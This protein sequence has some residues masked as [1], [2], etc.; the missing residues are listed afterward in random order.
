MYTP[1]SVGQRGLWYAQQLNPHLPFTVA[2]YVELRGPLDTGLVAAACD[3]AAREVESGVLFIESV[4]GE[5]HQRLEPDVD[6]A[7]G[8][9]DLGG[10][11]DPAVAAMRFMVEVYSRPLDPLR[12]RLIGTTLIRLGDDHHYLFTHVHHLALD[13]HGGMVLLTRAAELYTAW[14]TG[15][16]PPPLRAMTLARITEHELAYQGSARQATDRQHWAQ[17]LDRLPAPVT[18]SDGAA[19]AAP[20]C[21][22]VSATLGV[23]T[24]ADVAEL[25]RVHNS[26]DVPVVIAAFVSY[27]GRLTGAT[28]IGLSL[29]VSARTTAALRRSAGSMSNVVPLRVRVESGVRVADLVRRVQVELTGALRHQRYRYEDMLRDLHAV[30]DQRETRSAFGPAVNMMMFQPEIVFGCVTGE[31]HVLSTGPVDDLSLNVYP[32]VAGRS[33]RVDFEANPVRY[34]DTELSRH[35]RYFLDHLAAFARS[36]HLPVEAVPLGVP[37]ETA[38]VAPARGPRSSGTAMLPDLLT[39]H[40]DSDRVAVRDGDRTLTYRELDAR[41]SALAREIAGA[42]AGPD[43][44]VAVLLPRS[45]ALVVAVWA[46]AKAGAAYTPVDPAS[47]EQRLA[48][49]L[50]HAKVAI[51]DDDIRLPDGVTRLRA[52]DGEVPDEP[53]APGERVR[54]LR[55]DHVAWVIHT[56]GSSG[57]PKAVAVTHRGLAGLVDSLRTHYRADE[58]SRVLLLAAPS[59]DASMEELLLAANAGATLVVGPADAVAGADLAALLREQRVTH[60]AATPSVLAVTDPVDLPALRLVDAG[61]EALPPDVAG[62]W[63]TGRTLL[64]TY[65]PTEATVFA[66]L[67]GPLRADGGVPIGHPVHGMAAV[68]LDAR[69]RPLP[70]GAVG[71]LYLV[72]PALARGYVGDPAQTAT[73]FVASPYGR[74]YRTGDLVRWRENGLVFVGRSDRQVQIRG[75]R[76]EPAEVEV[77]LTGLRAVTAAAVVARGDRLDAYV[78][79][80]AAAEDIRRSLADLLPA[81]LVPSTLTVLGALPLTVSGKLDRPA[82]PAPV[83]VAGTGSRP[84]TGATETLVGRL[85]A[86]LVADEPG[87]SEPA[88]PATLGADTSFFTVGGHSLGAARLAGR[89]AAATG[90]EVHLRDVFDHPTIAELAAFVDTAPVLAPSR[91]ASDAGGLAPLAPAQQRLWLISQSGGAAYHLSVAL[92]FDG[93]LDLRALRAALGDVIDRHEPLRTVIS[94]PGPH[95]EVRPTAQVLPALLPEPTDADVD[96]LATRVAGW[97]ALPFDL[98]TDIPLRVRLLNLGRGRYVLVAVAHHIAVDGASVAVLVGDLAEAY[99][100]RLAGQAPAWSPLPLRFVDHAAGQHATLG[101]PADPSSRAA[102]EIAYWTRRL[103]GLG[104]AEGVPADHPRGPVPGPAVAIDLHVPAETLAPL[105]R[106]AAEHEATPFMLVH[107]AVAVWMSRWTGGRDVAVGTGT[108]GRDRPELDRLVGMFVGT[109]TLR[110]DVDPGASFSELLASSR[111]A[112]LDAHTHAAVPFDQVV[113]A[114]GYSPFQVMLAFDDVGTPDVVLPAVTVGV[115]EMNSPTARFDVELSVGQSADGTLIGRLIYDSSRFEHDTVT[116]AVADLHDVVTALASAPHSPVGE[117]A[118]GDRPVAVEPSGPAVTLPDLLVASGLRMAEPG[119]EALDAVQAATPLA[120]RLIDRGLGPEDRVAVVLP[121]SLDSVRAV[122]AVTLAGSA[123]VAV[124]PAQPESRIR[125]LLRGSQVRAAIAPP[126]TALPEGVERIDPTTEDSGRGPVTAAD[127][128]RPLVPDHAAYLVHTSGSTGIPKAVV[129]THRGLGPLAGDLRTRMSLDGSARVLHCASPTFDASMLEYLMAAAGGGTLVVAP[130]DVYGGDELLDLVREERIT[131]WFSTPAI[132]AQLDPSGLDTLR[133]LAVGGEAWS[134]E[135]ATR[136]APG[137]TMLN[138]YGPTETTVLAT[139][140]SPLRPGEPLTLGDGLDGVTALVLGPRLAPAP[141]GSIG[142]LYLMGPGLARGYLDDPAR[143][144]GRFVASPFGAGRMYRTGDLVRRVLRGERVQLVFAGRADEQVKVR[145]FRIEPG[146]VDATLAVHPGVAAAVTVMHGDG[147][148]SYVHGPGPL[149]AAELRAFLAARLPRHLVPATVTVLESLPL[150]RTGKIDR[151]ALPEPEIVSAA[152]GFRS[153]AEE[154]V[155]SIVSEVLSLPSVGATDDF[156]ALGGNSLS[157]TRLAARLG[158]AAGR[159]VAV[160]EVFDHPTVAALAV[161]LADPAAARRLPLLPAG[162]N[163]PAPLAAAQQR[164]WLVN[165]IDVADG[166]P[167]D[168]IAFAVDLDGSTGPDVLAA[169]ASDVLDRHAVLRTI[170]PDGADG[171]RQHVRNTVALDLT[172]RPE[173]ADLDAH[174]AD[175]ASTGFDL[176]VEPPL[177][178]RLYRRGPGHTLAVVLHHIAVDGLSLAPLGRD[179]AVALAARLEGH[180]PAWPPLAVSYRDYTLWQREVL[181][182]PADPQSLAGRQLAYWSRVLADASPVLTLPADRPGADSPGAAGR[183][184][185]TVHA[186]LH[187]AIDKLAREHDATPFMVMHAA[188]ALMLAGVAATEDVIV[189]TPVSGRVDELLDDVVGM[190]VGT[191]ALRLPVRPRATFAQ[192]LD[193]AR[194]VDLDALAHAD[195]PFDLVVDAL[196]RSASTHHPVF[197]VMFSYEGFAALPSE[198]PGISGVRE[199]GTGTARLDLDVTVRETRSQTGAPTGLD[200]VLTYD[201]GRYDHET[202]DEWASMLVRVLDAV[203]ADPTVQIGR[204]DLL[205]PDAAAGTGVEWVTGPPSIVRVAEQVRLRPDS[206]ALTHDDAVLTYRQLWS[207]S[208]ALA[209]MLAGR[210]IGTEDLVAVALPRSVD[211]VVA[212]VA[213]ARTGAAYLPLDVSHPPTRLAALIA[214]ARPALVLECA[215]VAVETDVCRLRVDTPEFGERL[216]VGGSYDRTTH[217]D[218]IGYVIHTSGSTGAPKGVAVPNSALASLF[219][220]TDSMGFGAGDVWPLVHSPAFDVSVWEMWGAL[221]TGGRLVVVD[222]YTVRDPQALTALVDREGVTVLNLTPTAFYQLASVDARLPSLRLLNFAGEAFDPERARAWFTS[223]P[224]VVATNLYGIT[225]TTVHATRGPAAAAGVGTALP[226]LDIAVLDSS[227]RTAPTGTTGELHVSGPQL[228]RGYSGRPGLTA[229]RFVAAPGGKRRYRSGDL[230]RRDRSGV[231]HHH[232]RADQQ[233]ELRGHRVEPGEVEAAL[234]RCPG[235][236]QA[237]VVL[238]GDR[239]V[240]YLVGGEPACALSTLRSAL[241]DHMVPSALVPLE[242]LPRTVNGKLD[243][244]ALPDPAPH[245]GHGTAPHS[246]LEELV[247]EVFRELVGGAVFA[248][249]DDFFAVGGNSLLATRLAGRLA[250]IAD[251]DVT[252]RDVFEAPTVAALAAVLGARSGRERLR[253]PLDVAPEGAATP[254]APAQQ[255][256]WFLSRLDPD[257][258]GYILPFTAVLDGELDVAALGA[259]IADVQRRHRTLRTVH[260]DIE[261]QV[262]LSPHASGVDPVDVQS[263]DIDTVVRDFVSVP[264]DLTTDLP[265]RVRLFRTAPRRHVLAVVIHH[266]A[267]DGWS[268]DVLLRDLASAYTARLSG[269]EPRWTPLPVHYT[270]YARHQQFT[271]DD[272]LEDWLAELADLP[273]EVTLPGDR[274]RPTRPSG[275][276]AT[277]R[278]TLDPPLSEGITRLARDGRATVFMVLH[279]ALAVLLTR[280][281]AGRDIAIGT[282]V[283]GRDDP[284]LDDLVG[285]FA[286]TL[287]LRTPVDADSAFTDLLS[288]VR[289]RDVAAFTRPDAPFETLVERLAPPR[290]SGRHPLFQVAL[291]LRGPAAE[292]VRLPGL[293][294][295]VLPLE[296]EY[297]NFDLQLT[298]TERGADIEVEFAYATDLYD[299]ETVA[300]FADRFDRILRSAVA[301]PSVRVGDMEL[302]TDGRVSGPVPAP[303]RSLWSLLAAGAGR[304][305]D[306]VA[307]SGDED[308]TYAELLTTAETLAACLI[309]RGVRPGDAVA[310]AIPRSH[311]SVVAVWAMVRAGAAPMFVDPEQPGARVESMLAGTVV[312]I[313]TSAYAAT[314]PASVAWIDVSRPGNEPACPACPSAA[315]PAPDEAAYF[316]FTSGTTGNPK[317]VAVTHRGVSA[318]V[319]DLS[320]RFG[321]V[322]GDRMLHV[323]SPTFDAAMLEILVA[324]TTGATL[325]VAPLDT[326]GGAPLGELIAERGVTHACLTPSALASLPA[327]DLPSLRVLMLG[328]E[329]VPPDL[330]D[331]WGSGRRLYN[332][333]GPAEGTVFVT[334]SPALTPGDVPVIGT[335]VR[336]V[337]AE[338]LDERLHPVPVGVAG[339]LYVSGDR[340]AGGYRRDSARTA[341]RFVAAGAGR[342]RY[343]TGDVVRVR[344]DGALEYLGRTDAQVK[345]RGVRIEPGEV[346]TALRAL[347]AVRRA[348]T[349]A[350]RG[351]LVS[352]V[353]PAETSAVDPDRVRERLREVLPTHLVPVAVVVV[354]TMPLTAHGKLDP[355]RLPDPPGADWTAPVSATEELVASTFADVLGTTSQAGRFDDFF[356]VGGNSLLVTE[357]IGRLREATGL[358][359]PLRLVFEHPTVEA[360]AAAVDAGTFERVAGPAAV[361]PRPDRIPLSRAQHRL[362]VS[363]SLDPSA[364]RLQVEV[365]FTGP[366]DEGA[367]DAAVT[368]VIERHEI[369]RSSVEVDE[370]GPHLVVHDRAAVD[371]RASET[372]PLRHGRVL[373]VDHT[374]AD[375]ASLAPLLRDLATA[376]TARSVGSE[377]HWAALPLQYADYALWERDRDIDHGEQERVE[378][379]LDELDPVALPTE[380]TGVEP[381]TRTVNF[382]IPAETRARIAQLGRAHGATEFMVVHAALSVLLSRLGAGTDVTIAAVVSTR[383]W[384][385]LADVVGPF[386]QTLPLRA[387]V[388]PDL[389]FG[390]V[391]DHVRDVDVAA[392][393]NATAPLDPLAV[394]AVPQVALA[395]QDFAPGPVRIGDVEVEAREIVPDSAPKFDLHIALTP[396]PDGYTGALVYDASRFGAATVRRLADRFVAVVRAV[397]SAPQAEV[398]DIAVDTAAPALVGSRPGAPATLPELLRTAA[399][400]HPDREALREGDRTLTYRELDTRTDALAEELRTSGAAPGVVIPIDLPR[401]L[402]HVCMLWAV[403]KTGAAF[404]SARDA[405]REVPE[406]VAYIV[407]TSGSTGTPKLVAVTHRGLGP[408]AAE[409]AVRY[410]VGPGDRVLHGYDPAFDAALLEIL[411]AHTTGATLV[412]APA[413]VYAGEELQA[414]LQRERVTH[415]LSTPA[416]LGTLDPATLPDLRVVASGGETLPAALAARW[417]ARGRRMLDA[418]GPTEATIVATLT[419]VDGRGGIGRPI[420]GTGAEVLDSRLSPVPVDAVGELYLSGTSLAAGYLGEPGMTA[421]RFVAAAGGGRRYRTGDLVHRRTDDTLAYRGRTDRQV[422]VRGVR[423]EPGEIEAALLRDPAVRAAVA[424]LSRDALVAFVAADALDPVAARAGLADVVPP[425]RMPTRV[426]VVP[427]LPTTRNGKVDTAALRALDAAALRA[428][429]IAVPSVADR[430]VTSAERRVLAV[431]ESVIGILPHPDS[432]F[433]AAGG[434]SLSA[435]TVAARLAGEFGVAVPARSILRAPTL[436]AL[437]VELTSGAP[438]PSIP[439]RRFEDELPVPLAPAQERLWVLARGGTDDGAYA[440]PVALHLTGDLDT[441]ALAA[442]VADV[443][444]RHEVL[445][446]AYPNGRATPVDPP[447]LVQLPSSDPGAVVAD[448]LAGRFDLTIEPPLR[449][450]LIAVGDHEWVLAGALHHSAFDGASLDPLLGDLRAA[451]TARSAGTTPR[452]QPLPVR[453]RDFAH[454]QHALLGDPTDA[455]SL[456]AR[457]LDHWADVLAGLPESPLPLPADRIRPN[458]PSGRGGAV[459]AHLDAT[460][461]RR[462]MEFAQK[463]DVSLFM[464]LHAAL[465]VMLARRSGRADVAVGTVVSGR[466]DPRLRMLVGMFVGTLTLRTRIDAAEPFAGLLRRVRTVDLD[467][468]AH[469]DVPFDRVVER[470]APVRGGHHPLFQILLAHRLVDAGGERLPSFPGLTVRE[471]D[472]GEP[473]AQFD[474]AFDVAERGDIGGVDVRVVYAADL[475]DRDTGAAMLAEY[476]AVLVDAVEHPDR[477]VGDLAVVA[478]APVATPAV[479]ARTLPRILADTVRAHPGAIAIRSGTLAWT[480]AGLDARASALAGELY[481]RGVGRGDVVAIALPRGPHWPLAVW[482]I[483]RIGA[484][485]MSIDPAHPP[486]RI[487]SMLQDADVHVGLAEPGV[488]F[489]APG[490]EWLDATADREAREIPL[491]DADL[492]D[493]AYLVHTSGSTGIPKAVAVPHRGL[494]ALVDIQRRVLGHGPGRRILAVSAYTFDAAV[495]DLLAAHAHGATMVIAPPDVYAGR[496]LQDMIVDE[497]ITHLGV[498]PT[499][500]GTLDP[501]AL[502]MP[503]TVVSAGELL[504]APLATRWHRHRLFNGYGP[505]ESTVAVSMGGPNP[506]GTRPVVGA[507]VAGTTGHV[508]DGRLHPVPVG[509]IGEL[510]VTGAGLARGYHQQSGLTATRFV[511]DPYGAHGGR[512]YRTGDLARITQSGELDVVGRMDNQIQ[513]RGIRVEPSE[514]DAVLVG[515]HGVDAAVTVAVTGPAGD[516]TLVSYAGGTAGVAELRALAAARLP[517]GVR[518]TAIAVLPTLPLLPS[519]KVDRSALPAPVFGRHEDEYVAP[520]GST[521]ETIA[522]I[523]AG[524]LAVDAVSADLNYFDLGGTSLGALDVV[525]DLRTEF[526][527]DLPL[528]WL[529]TSPTLQAFADRVDGRSDDGGVGGHDGDPLGTLVP[530]GGRPDAAPLFCVHPISG[531][532]WC[533]AGLATHLPDAAVHGVQATALQPL[534]GTLTGF[535]RRYVERLRSV[536]PEGPYRLLGWSVGGVVAHEMAVQ[537]QEAGH[538]VSVLILLDSYSADM[539]PERAPHTAVPYVELDVP[540]LTDSVVD[541]IRSRAMAAGEAIESAAVAHRPRRFSGDA[542]VIRAGVDDHGTRPDWDRYIDGAVAEH[543]VPHAHADLTTPA[544]LTAVGPIV[545]EYLAAR[546]CST[547]GR[548]PNSVTATRETA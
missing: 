488:E 327:R 382:E 323:A 301:D 105:R 178:T 342:R 476:I 332:G 168:L 508:L 431:A 495:F 499:V 415:Y 338:I 166:V 56:S 85:F 334:C 187:S 193:A 28:D 159:R 83:V 230:G 436:A 196:G 243:R 401:G 216:R 77:A 520:R 17:R 525:A 519:G 446:T 7:P 30:G 462:A 397:V 212:I 29:P 489:E 264:F 221:T 130:A 225:E 140:G 363:G 237:A 460:L 24:A 145:G 18:L 440:V 319:D 240:G 534:P 139:A 506:T 50:R 250:A 73:R 235:V 524:H 249:S 33:L 189:G 20:T 272:V 58:D 91:V 387:H 379:S 509:V 461:H 413:A 267:A 466:D 107:T 179:L 455:G 291:S 270:D 419:D 146:E 98:T 514:V 79:A 201:A 343:R 88:G 303:A 468:I 485:W 453:Y 470:L 241:P 206:V 261:T 207:R 214:D 385:V 151:T 19:P 229:T 482:A 359:V 463:H 439:L 195:V 70:I 71:E 417:T 477:E 197:Q 298:V 474:L 263:S 170:H 292:T 175:F 215:E 194:H 537:L 109:V 348:A 121:R 180:A 284:R 541:D 128:V 487:A 364:Y 265:L 538:E 123:F 367:L 268:L 103:N 21:R 308:V 464:V 90:R 329:S 257:A 528:E 416:V 516:R 340:V 283:A 6:D 297:S 126:G 89:L 157:A 459:T 72:G 96:D 127:R 535:A 154:L 12:D 486:S 271:A 256:L 226:G 457:Q 57:T 81:Y 134:A 27:L 102:H 407:A 247:A 444:D 434:D 442:A 276:G 448:L 548:A 517:R 479:A 9:L 386:L 507:P 223:H 253:R 337:T 213:V 324:G 117:L 403:T 242:A 86:E 369:L 60:L 391:L 69:L 467:A 469:A 39:R 339:E 87:R 322:P 492:D 158:A 205:G 289:R 361:H 318:L 411:L 522:A 163:E 523:I 199:L 352:Y 16:E 536:Q 515:H 454:W 400:A 162:G 100:A 278:L 290:R 513:L 304:G 370:H 75:Q 542:L 192:L 4:G 188:L 423:V 280:H 394:G 45:V 111:A 136:W 458:R 239:L 156:F 412:V 305:G 152:T 52:S 174:L 483:T 219:T 424:M 119:G 137:R 8:Y 78:V 475:F 496:P 202:V 15:L 93:D 164:L 258:T 309:A 347:P 94:E 383:R 491:T 351:A 84:L 354:D 14:A 333:Y 233:I 116:A 40:A 68:V 34:D 35:H 293:E 504:P 113:E 532:S 124:D 46:V 375:G 186:E 160:R 296:S 328:G 410:R 373:T 48:T 321:T 173:P 450:R 112:V 149:V 144:A 61:G 420:P 425:H 527:N 133:V 521:A 408:L 429:D 66:T 398:G 203:T 544:A 531:M 262:V 349:V 269:D 345:L 473:A 422:K 472:A 441:Q 409:G 13:G 232:G 480:Y 357:L 430:P 22:H 371:V 330:V 341:S 10:S 74:A 135:T 54:P 251:V 300:A 546:G 512:L 418:Y 317:A 95:Q 389:S 366:V 518:P 438:A 161:A 396:T 106:L 481:A 67:G 381:G 59:F 92:H 362:W 11:P 388:S 155:A 182:D 248:A 287:V 376:Y 65:G 392:F 227:L 428:S 147:L 153:A 503:V 41:S 190:F 238:R 380:D 404:T 138:V 259:A 493:V 478:P 355:G 306:G 5:P 49:L 104:E 47:S 286:G 44:C 505:S 452:W 390:R 31:L 43:D 433:Y 181:G 471:Y 131:H 141:V 266:I 494:T 277:H 435:V 427:Q 101:D 32:A 511:A 76:V 350:R 432:S 36:A 456:A 288:E 274:P 184:T 200:G 540:G 335:P 99:T 254:L 150:T 377:P 484:A 234:L 497:G 244:A 176:T 26:T 346:D 275:H 224:H 294:V 204:I 281:G 314:L 498:T 414:L 245:H 3:R 198:I 38:T 148:A 490:V 543:S 393:D 510:Y 449:I 2:Q 533:Y 97:T 53:F 210:G 42:G 143:T 51:C 372:T 320:E 255:R 110:V 295:Q 129:V 218:A 358:A 132:P 279:T 378:R 302:A 80:S 220:A 421:A 374:A 122:V 312:G 191:T 125:A 299:A 211:L 62:R 316:V 246:A 356:A 406:H 273:A 208:G 236:T 228:A 501:D 63:S 447:H 177:R 142:E 529:M 120:W 55:P 260:P 25:A 326:F 445:R 360:L 183:I 426:R 115:Q 530:L 64:N 539:L 315:D 23:D 405:A 399:A 171:P 331:R 311:L 118:V 167:G 82:L 502:P 313:T 1:V 165:R 443:V 437:A 217:P 402:D 368:D 231:L 465:A 325:V 310:C 384:A 365:T 169:A 282:A 336:G 185:F 172:P 395:I 222:H 209:E 344:R 37:A 545:A 526:G 285:M 307:V 353:E 108:A 114:L 500:L 547:P 451:Y 252:V